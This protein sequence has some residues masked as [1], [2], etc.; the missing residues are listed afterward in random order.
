MSTDDRMAALIAALGR[1]DALGARKALAAQ[2]ESPGDLMAEL[3]RAAAD[4]SALACE[5]LV[6]AIDEQGLA[7]AAV[8]RVLVDESAIDDVTQDTLI[9]VA[10]GIGSFRGDAKF[11]TWLHQVARN[12]AVDYL[13]RQRATA[14]LNDEHD[15]GPAERMSSVIASRESA[16][17]LV[18]RLPD[19]Y[20][21][22]VYLRDVK[23]ASYDDVAAQL[24]VTLNTAKSRISR[25]RALLARMLDTEP[26]DG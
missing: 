8:H 20:R 6:E 26:W 12:R 14:P 13:R 1:A 7:R 5:L 17:Q 23:Q 25:G 9:S 11:T 18:E 19:S 22:A 2:L 4:G 16:R 15:L 24:G 21:Q 10:T 3:A